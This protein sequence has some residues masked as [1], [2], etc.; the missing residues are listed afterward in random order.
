MP[1]SG[2]QSQTGRHFD[3]WA[4]LGLVLSL[5]IFYP[6]LFLFKAA[7]LTGDHLEQHYPWAM[8]LADSL[9]HFRLPFWTPY[10]HAGFPIAAE[11]QIA[12]FYLP[13]L[14]LYFFLP[15]KV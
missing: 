10:I 9:K 4:L 15:F 8:L 2:T 1:S 5:F 6:G 14:L 11:S 7:P 3:L 12:I 13:H